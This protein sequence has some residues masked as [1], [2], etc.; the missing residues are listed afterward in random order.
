MSVNTSALSFRLNFTDGTFITLL[1]RQV[2]TEPSD[3]G[4][5]TLILPNLLIGD[6]SG[7]SYNSVKY[8]FNGN[9]YEFSELGVV[10]NDIHDFRATGNRFVMSYDPTTGIIDAWKQSP[11]PELFPYVSESFLNENIEGICYEGNVSGTG[12]SSLGE[13]IARGEFYY[14]GDSGRYHISNVLNNT[15]F[16]TVNTFMAARNDWYLWSYAVYRTVNTSM[17]GANLSLDKS[18]EEYDPITPLI[19]DDDPLKPGGESDTGGGTGDFDGTGDDID[20]PSLPTVSATDTGFIT[21]FNPSIAQLKNLA[22]YMWS[23]LFDLNAYRKLF[24]D[25]MDCILGLS[26]VPVAVPNGSSQVVKVG[27][28]STGISMTT[29][30]SQYV[31]VDCGSLNVNEY[32]GAYLDYDPYTKAE[33]YLPYIGT[34]PIAVDDIM[35]KNVTVKYHVDILSGACTAYVKCGGS[36]LYTFI[37]QCSSSIPITANDWTNVINGVL[38]IAG[39]IGTMVATGGL[40]APVSAG[41][42]MG[43]AATAG[44]IASTAINTMKPSIEKSGSMSGTGGM[45]SIQTPY[46]IL[47]RPR[48]A[49]PSSQNSFIGYPS[50]ITEYL[51]GLSGYTEIEAIHLDG[52]PATDAEIQE[53]ETLLYKGVIF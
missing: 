14:E 53:L 5:Y 51:G 25:P 50:F 6:L 9:K 11:P 8:D 2:N 15:P 1:N 39:S 22:S 48:Q 12:F 20:I 21:L 30:A 32:W 35:K 7:E 34:H 28:I 16:F 45:L 17:G 42:V 24:A 33:I 27:N 26:L 23:G 43:A 52:V 4:E 44:T 13:L 10:I 41:S 47:T 36:V 49:L 31:E 3:P 18:V 38:S 29:A 37:G 40:S 46:L 19:P